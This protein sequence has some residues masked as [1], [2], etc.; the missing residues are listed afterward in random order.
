M[1]LLFLS[2]GMVLRL[3]GI[4]CLRRSCICGVESCL[5]PMRGGKERGGEWRPLRDCVN[6]ARELAGKKR[7]ATSGQRKLLKELGVEMWRGIANEEA[8]ALIEA[9]NEARRGKWR[10]GEITAKQIEHLR[11]MGH[12]PDPAMSKGEASDIIDQLHD[13]PRAQEI[14]YYN[15][16]VKD[17]PAYY[18]VEKGEGWTQAES[19][20][21]Q[22]EIW[23]DEVRGLARKLNQPLPVEMGGLGAVR[24]EK[25]KKSGVE[26]RPAGCN[27]VILL[28]IALLV[29]LIWWQVRQLDAL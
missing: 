20:E 17:G 14:R 16:L 24:P 7:L 26:S 10:D 11:E 29:L 27:A 28:G 4:I 23:E 1:R 15:M 12:E 2:G 5:D 9:H 8:S 25:V 21:C 18:P 3:A 13:D 19:D 6:H 22:R